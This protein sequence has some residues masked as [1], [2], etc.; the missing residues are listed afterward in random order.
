MRGLAISLLLA[1]A[2][3]C[4]SFPLS[5][6]DCVTKPSEIDKVL[7]GSEIEYVDE[8][9]RSEILRLAN[10]ISE[11]DLRER[12]AD[13]DQWLGES[14][15]SCSRNNPPSALIACLKAESAQRLSVLISRREELAGDRQYDPMNLG[16]LPL[17]IVK[18]EDGCV[19]DLLIGD[20]VVARC[21]YR[22]E[23]KARYSDDKIDAMAL[24]ANSGGAPYISENFPVYIVAV[25]RDLKAEVTR[26]PA[27]HPGI[28]DDALVRTARSPNGFVFKVDPSPE[29][30]GWRQEWTFQ[31]GLSPPSFSKFAPVA[32]TTMARYD[33]GLLMANEQFYRA[34]QRFAGESKIPFATL[35][36]AFSW[37]GEISSL[38]TDD[39][40][41]R[42]RVF[43][44]CTRPGP[45]GNCH[46]PL[47]RVLYDRK[48]DR[49]YFI[50]PKNADVAC[51]GAYKHDAMANDL[52]DA[53][54]FPPRKDWPGEML[55]TLKDTFCQPR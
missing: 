28:N 38:T 54:Y 23:P 12:L 1:L 15:R 24:V 44:G 37:S 8:Q 47:E 30:G 31:A 18:R 2:V 21:V 10:F 51:V 40:T 3:L 46:K 5:A 32:G 36:R 50:L 49:L 13:Q 7:C 48:A 9:M 17:A 34:L 55:G 29:D 11:Q 22:L 19:G 25:T 43:G 41:G 6:L 52:A 45:T 20:K 39:T 26:V 35:A 53:T 16:G 42:F 27:R 33:G 4:N 14:V